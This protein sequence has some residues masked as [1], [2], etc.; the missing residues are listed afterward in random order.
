MKQSRFSRAVPIWADNIK[1]K[2]NVHLKLCTYVEKS[3]KVTLRIATASF[4]Q[5]FVNGRY[6]AFGPARAGRGYFRIDEIALDDMLTEKSNK[7][8]I[9]LVSYGV[10]NYSNINQEPFVT[11][12][13]LNGYECVSAT[14]KNGFSLYRMTNYVQ[15]ISRYSFQRGFAE[16][17]IIDDEH[18][19]VRVDAKLCE[20]KQYITRDV[21]YPKYES[22]KSDGFIYKGSFCVEKQNTYKKLLSEQRGPEYSM[23]FSPPEESM[24]N[25]LQELQYA[26]PYKI[27]ENKAKLTD[28]EYAI[29]GFEREGTGMICF[30]CNALADSV[31][32]VTY[33]EKL[34]SENGIN[35]QRLDCNAAVRYVL[36]KGEHRLTTFEPASM[37]YICFSL[38]CGEAEIHDVRLI[39]YKHPPATN[40][41]KIVDT[42]LGQI[43]EAAIETFRQNAVD[44]FTD[45]PSR[46][47]AGWL[48]DSFFLGR[49]ETYLFGS[50]QVE[51][52]FLENF[53]MEDKFKYLPEGM[54]PMCYPA[55]HLDE[56]YIPNWAMWLV[57]ELEDYYCRTGDRTLVDAY[58]KKIFDLADF[59][60][61]Y[62]NNDG[63]LERLDK[64][65]FIDWSESNNHVQDV[66]FPSNMMYAY[67]LEKIAKLYGE[68]KLIQKAEQIKNK[69]RE[70]AF[71]GRFFCD[72]LI[73]TDTGYRTEGIRTESCQYYAFFTG[74]ATRQL[75]PELWNTLISDFG[76][77]RKNKNSYP[78]IALSN[79]F[80]GNY[81]R[82]ELLLRENMYDELL[83]N[84]KGYFGYMAEKTGTLWEKVNADASMNH[85]FA[86]YAAVLIGKALL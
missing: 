71:D 58:K 79:A 66:S 63:L 47:R 85:G 11:C 36:K 48:C 20:Q 34:N 37:K 16:S 72:N 50:N 60:A 49:T 33:D 12:E 38:L 7:I 70:L 39:E 56:T 81:L 57:L 46:E 55:D 1:E 74:T 51:K 22:M 42:K 62:E 3:E 4:Y 44:I 21:P 24:T 26:A 6:T 18:L 8:E 25:E 61:R 10:D 23:Q 68:N 43:Y 9:I 45:C 69:I 54:L 73:K 2:K 28:N 19:P 14:G 64:W 15:S 59:F 40:A 78:D 30:E 76:F 75:Y 67:M 13:I 29:C 27:S 32:Y 53:L 41:G 84:I 65:V 82:L 35:A 52:N 5:L 31:F 80:T 17:Y 86:S 83:E 77:E